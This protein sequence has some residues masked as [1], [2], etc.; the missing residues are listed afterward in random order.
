MAKIIVQG[1]E[2]S[3]SNVNGE[4]YISL[5]YMAHSQMQEHIVFRWMSVRLAG[6]EHR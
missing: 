5:T 1:T 3:V 4:D 6:R 2:I